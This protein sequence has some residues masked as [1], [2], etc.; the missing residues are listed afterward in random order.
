MPDIRVTNVSNADESIGSGFGGNVIWTLTLSEPVL[1]AVTVGWRALPGTAIDSID[2]PKSSGTVIFAPQEQTKTI[3]IRVY[4]DSEDETDEAFVLELFDPTNADFA[5]GAK[6]VRSTA[7]ILDDD[8]LGPD[9]TVFV[10]SPIVVEGDSGTTL[11]EFEVKLSRPSPNPLTF[12]Y[13]T[14]DGS[15]TAGSDYTAMSGPITFQAGQTSVI[16]RVPVIGDTRIEPSEFFF[17]SVVPNSEMA[18]GG[19]GA[20]GKATILDDDA[21]SGQPT[22]SLEATNAWESIGSGFGGTAIFTVTLSE[23]SL[24]A[25]SLGYRTLPGTATDTIDYPTTTGTLDFAPGQTSK[26]IEVRVRHD[27][28]DEADES[29]VLELFDPRNASFAGDQKVLRDVS[30]VLDDDGLGPNR[31]LHVSSPIVVEGDAGKTRVDFEITLS[32]P[33]TETLIF[34]YET[35]NGTA[36]A[37]SDYTAKSGTVSFAPGQTKASVSVDVNGDRVSES[38]EFFHLRVTPT[39]FIADGGVG[40]T[41]TATIIDDDSGDRPT[42]SVAS[43]NAW[44]SIGSGFGGTSNF[45][46]TLSE[47]SANAVSVDYRSLQGSAL[48]IVDYPASSGTLTFAPG[49]TSKTVSLRVNSDSI[50]E[51]DEAFFMEFRNPQNAV[52]AGNAR[53]FRETAFILDDDGLGPNLAFAVADVFVSGPRNDG[54]AVAEFIVHLSRAQTSP[55]SL[56]Y[57]TNDDTA[58]AGR[59]YRAQSGTLTFLPGQTKAAILVP[60]IENQRLDGDLSFSISFGPVPPMFDSAFTGAFATATIADNGL[61]GTGGN[62]SLMGSARPDGILGLGGDDTLF[63]NA[64]NDLL[65]GGEGDDLLNGGIGFDVLHGDAGNDTLLG[66]DG[67]DTLYG[68]AGNDRLSGNAGNDLLYG[69]EGDD[70]LN[71][72]IG[73]DV[74]HGDA[75][76]DTLVGLEGFD[77]LY[78]GAGNDTLQGNAGNDLLY[79]GTGADRLE[80]GIGFDTLHGDDGNDLIYGGNGFDVLFGGA[81]NDRL[82]G[83]AGNDTLDGGAGNDVL[84]GGIGADTFVFRAGY[85]QDR[86]ADFQNNVDRIHIDSDLLGGGTPE[87]IDLAP[88][89]G[90]TVDGFLIL[91]FGGGDTLVFTGVST[92]AS[93]LDEVV[94]I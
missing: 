57:Q 61:R 35:L 78:G 92:L 15:A 31:G 47:A 75:G 32:R 17:L 42:I 87:P 19:L 46:V 52:L 66:L 40:S 18:D 54:L 2:Y 37:G 64:G 91:D 85:G 27:T 63:G 24:N 4:S 30:F 12:T 70:L 45:T 79:G 3:S 84:V 90:S 1:N 69:G 50:D 26:T 11:A 43:T 72:G 59:D 77:T 55:I 88:F 71:G 39:Q 29:F 28:L 21:G 51:A 53:I 49:E 23:P 67:F 22:V 68:G 93:I 16:V 86:V 62:D 20:T 56:T 14:H 74:M 80:G 81:G 33:A 48:E 36:L 9:R 5:G 13:S 7:F 41:G 38:S 44:E 76:N 82:E 25:V 10:G 83:N 89:A 34:S 73:F 60:I 65:Y 58:I 94:F 6:V 8:G